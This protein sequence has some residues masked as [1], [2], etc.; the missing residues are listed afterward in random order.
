[1]GIWLFSLWGKMNYAALSR[2][3][4]LS[5]HVFPLLFGRFLGGSTTGLSA[6]FTFDFLRSSASV[7]PSCLQC[8]KLHRGTSAVTLNGAG[9]GL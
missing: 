8:L 5:A 1:M 9:A 3:V 6:N 2:P 4:S 7:S